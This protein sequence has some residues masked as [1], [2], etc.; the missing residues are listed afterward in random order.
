MDRHAQ[1]LFDEMP[2]RNCN[3]SVLSLN[4]LLAAYLH[5]KKYDVVEKLF[6]DL[7]VQL[8]V[9]PDLVSYNTFIKALLE[10]G[11]FDSAVAVVEEMEK[12]GVKS[13]LITFNTLLDGLYSKGRFE[14]GE[15][16]WGKL[17]EK[18]VVPNIRTYNARL[19]GLA[20][21]K[22]TGEA[23]EFYEEMVKKGVKPDI[24]SFNALIKGFANE[25]NLDEAK[26]WY[27]EIGK[28][29][30]DPDKATYSIIV[31]FLCEKGDL[32][33]VLEMVKE[34]FY[35]HCRV[36][37]SLLQ[38]AVDKLLSESMVSEA[39]EIV[40]RGKTNNYCRYKLNLPA[41]ELPGDE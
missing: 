32:K 15:K 41:D 12:E 37:A 6:R 14:D 25:G 13:D 36:E 34:I 16:L 39:K 18:N 8:S 31:P 21:V 23:V 17:G 4:A 9:K 1:K 27:G 3:R 38:V 11:S 33:T 20:M 30:Y 26:K 22:K 19:L 24:F 10:M 29:E 7:P 28:S 40:E 2:Q 35:T 5:S